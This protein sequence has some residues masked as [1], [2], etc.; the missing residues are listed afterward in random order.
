MQYDFTEDW[1]GWKL[2]GGFLVSPD[3]QHLTRERLEGLL[4]RDAQELRLAGLRSRREAMKPR[5]MVRVVVVELDEIRQ[6]G[7]LAG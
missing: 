6:R 7:K 1:H 2:R 4:W 3:R 5:Q